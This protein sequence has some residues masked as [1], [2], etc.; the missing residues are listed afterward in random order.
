MRRIVA[1]T[2]M[3]VTS[4][5]GIALAQSHHHDDRIR[6]RSIMRMQHLHRK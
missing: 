5:I 4:I 1:L 3:L 2:L 6:A